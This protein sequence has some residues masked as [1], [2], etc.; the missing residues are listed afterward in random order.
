MAARLDRE[1]IE[2]KVASI[3]ET[4][5]SGADPVVLNE[6]RKIIN[7]EVS[8]FRRSWVAAW[9]LMFYDQNGP[10]RT[11][12]PRTENREGS[13]Q[14][15]VRSTPIPE[16]ETKQLFISI[17][18]NRHVYPREILSLIMAKTSIPREDI[19]VIRILDNYSFVQVRENQARRVIDVLNG[20]L[21]RGRTLIVDYAKS[22]KEETGGADTADFDSEDDLSGPEY[23]LEGDSPQQEEDYQDKEDI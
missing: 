16:A 15:R 14:G 4:V 13:A 23:A 21:F 18:R 12:L 6:Y 1:N 2:N 22:K 3:L 19:G 17:G 20:L 9:L 7:K 8:F 5:H 10:S 11:K